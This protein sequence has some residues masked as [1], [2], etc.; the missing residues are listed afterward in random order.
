MLFFILYSILNDAETIFYCA[1]IKDAPIDKLADAILKTENEEYIFLF[2][3][4]VPNVTTDILID[5]ILNSRN[6]D[7][8][9]NV[10]KKVPNAPIDKLA[11]AIIKANT[12][13]GAPIEKLL[14][15]TLEIN[16]IGIRTDEVYRFALNLQENGQI[17][18]DKL[19]TAIIESGN[20]EYIYKFA[21]DIKNAPIDILADAIIKTGNAEYIYKFASDIY[22][23]PVKKLV[24][25]VIKTGSANN[26]YLFARFVENAPIV[27]LVDAIC[28]TRDTYYILEFARWVQNL[29]KTSIN[30]L[31]NAI[32]KCNDS[33][34]IYV[35]AKQIKNAPINKLCNALCRKLSSY[36]SFEID[37]S[38]EARICINYLIQFAAKV[39]CTYYDK[40][41]NNLKIINAI[42]K[43]QHA[44][45]ILRLAIVLKG[46]YVDIL[47]DA[48]CKYGYVRHL[49][50][51]AKEVENTP[52]EKLRISKK[53]GMYIAKT[54]DAKTI[55]EYAE[56][57][58]GAPIYE[59][60]KGIIAT[61]DIQYIHD[62]AL[63]I[64]MDS[65][66]F[67]LFLEY[68]KDKY[69]RE[70]FELAVFYELFFEK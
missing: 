56:D 10:A 16:H 40:L 68:F 54:K 35:F 58:E 66:T 28:E 6:S 32:I 12:L 69:P 51:F 23:A 67:K 27:K 14:N 33:E 5:F 44:D 52:I 4:T 20:A 36:S 53:L 48:I 1:F 31:A 13:K 11:D 46:Q 47:S 49:Y 65:E 41:N 18:F 70:Y 45:S 37:T 42:I 21:K 59:L 17:F 39:P 38:N 61:S 43:T 34:S 8:I 19:V 50:S 57:I 29:S 7:Y 30:K 26:I 64:T 24:D 55:Y 22:N 62:F 15:A 63:K 25:A 3:T 60:A 2:L 9:Y